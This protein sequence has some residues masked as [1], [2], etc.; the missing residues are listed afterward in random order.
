MGRGG[1]TR[2]RGGRR[3]TRGRSR[4]LPTHPREKGPEVETSYDRDLTRVSTGVHFFVLGSY[5]ELCRS[6]SYTR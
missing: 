6:Y 3:S 2:A 4:G 1:E 5:Q